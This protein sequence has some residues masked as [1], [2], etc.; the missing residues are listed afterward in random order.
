MKTIILAGGRG[1]RM[2]NETESIPKPMVMIGGK[3]IIEHIMS[4]YAHFGFDE[5]IILG[6]YRYDIIEQYFELS[7]WKCAVVDTGLNTPTSERLLMLENRIRKERFML[8]YGDGLSNIDL[9]ALCKNHEDSKKCVTISG[10]HPP[11]R[12]GTLGIKDGKIINFYEKE[13]LIAEWV[14]GGFMVM[15]PE[16]FDYLKKGEMLEFYTL[17]KLLEFNTLNAYLHDGWWWP[18]DTPRDKEVLE[19]LWNERF[20]PWRFK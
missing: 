17:P 6:G 11:S 20:C 15:E 16:V 9:K 12:F 13:R 8:T 7:D 3:P 14:N 2:G 4:Y 10:V 5:F 1:T 19:E 18:M